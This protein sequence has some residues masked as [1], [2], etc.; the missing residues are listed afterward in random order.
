MSDTQKRLAEI[1]AMILP[2]RTARMFVPNSNFFDEGGHS[3]LVQQLFFRLRQEWKDLDMPLRVIFQSQT[4]ES[5]A[6]EIDRAQDPIGLRLD[7]MPLTGDAAVDDEAYAAD[8]RGLVEQLPP[9]IPSALIS[10]DKVSTVFLTGATGF[11]GSYILGELLERFAQVRV[12]ALM[13]ATD[14]AEGLTRLEATSTLYGLWSPKWSSRVEVVIGDLA[15]PQLGLSPALWERLAESVDLIIHNGAQVHWMLPYSSLRKANVL[16]TMAC[17]QL[18]ATGRAKRLAFVSST[19]TLDNDY[20]ATEIGTT[21]LET[22]D[23]EGSRKGLGTGYGQSKWTSEY[24]VRAAGQRGLIG[25]V[26]RPGYITGDLTSGTSITDDFL[27]RLWK[28][29]V[30]VGARPEINTALNAV[31]VTHVSRIIVAAALHLPAILEGKLGVSQV[32]AH[33]RR[34]LNEWMAA[35]QE[36]G[37]DV[38]MVDY[39][40]WCARARAYVGDNAQM[41]EFALLPLYH[42]I[43]ED[44]PD[45]T[46]GPTL[47]DAH[48]AAALRA[49]N[50]PEDA[51]ATTAV[52]LS[53]LGKYLAYL[54][55]VGFM[56]E[57]AHKGKCA[58]PQVKG[59]KPEALGG[60]SKRI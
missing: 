58:L 32:T 11:L 19:A 14:T 9:S 30:Q 56:P 36:Y 2:N 43:I 54:V 57:P 49:Y 22:D 33:P 42:F 51:D 39:S 15:Q 26:I 59:A 38:P 46:K 50:A 13:R 29:S 16:S 53:T 12:I 8:A 27:V 1:W 48:T 35:P 4:L 41:E 60:R 44:L 18:C 40:E 37:Y 47:D 31:P 21:V 34:T 28:A 10:P 3:I 17:I 7:T 25:A 6:A 24:I 55:A 52:S 5:L 45:K 20:Y 23:L